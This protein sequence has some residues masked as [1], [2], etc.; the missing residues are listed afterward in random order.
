M[1]L[2][3]D[4]LYHNIFVQFNSGIHKLLSTLYN[5]DDM[6]R[7]RVD[8]VVKGVN[9]IFQSELIKVFVSSLINKLKLLNDSCE[10]IISI[11][12]ILNL[13]TNPFVN[14][15]S[16]HKKLNFLSQ[17]GSYIPPQAIEIGQ[18]EEYKVYKN[19][20]VIAVSFE[21]VT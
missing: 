7:S 6:P 10:S 1:E 19:I 5:Y 11:Q 12:T 2:E 18:R 14:L 21:K 9:E 13:I 15:E 3:F 17:F 8:D 4:L 16:E 20:S